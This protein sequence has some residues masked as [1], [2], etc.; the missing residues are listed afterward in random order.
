MIF[1]QTD[2]RDFIASDLEAMLYIAELSGDM[3]PP[4]QALVDGE[5]REV[6]EDF[7]G[8]TYLISRVARN[9]E[10]TLASIIEV[11]MNAVLQQL[12]G[13][14]FRFSLRHAIN[15]QAIL[16]ETLNENGI[17]AFSTSEYIYLLRT[18][19]DA[20]AVPAW[21]VAG[22]LEEQGAGGG[23]LPGTNHAQWYEYRSDQFN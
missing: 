4:F 3:R 18:N 9:D 21:L 5:L 19:E 10:T 1:L 8:E 7:L 16:I 6:V 22:A 2:N 23:V 12:G 13:T 15:H 20:G 17:F 14:N 11:E